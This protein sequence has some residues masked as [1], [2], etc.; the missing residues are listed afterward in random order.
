MPAELTAF[1]KEKEEKIN[2]ITNE[3]ISNIQETIKN[4]SINGKVVYGI[5]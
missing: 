3:T 5:M 1:N 4:L 2:T